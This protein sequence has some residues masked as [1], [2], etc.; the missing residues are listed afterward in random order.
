M[1]ARDLRVSDAE[2]E[3][4]GRLLQRAVGRGMLSLGE[5]TERMDTALAAKTRGELNVVLADLP[6]LRLVDESTGTRAAAQVQPGDPHV[7]RGRLS[8]L[9]RKGPWRVPAALAT[10]TQMA[11]VT[12]DFTKAIIDSQVV[13]LSLDDYCSSHTLIVP[14]DATVDVNGLD[15]IGGSVKTKVGN[16]PPLGHPHIVVTGRLRFGSITI[17]RPGGWKKLLTQQQ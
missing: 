15:L 17:K 7:L 11:S 5:F 1:E 9:E 12:L 10:K 8:S 13:E 3:H 16:G 6:G 14:P 4:V 2:R